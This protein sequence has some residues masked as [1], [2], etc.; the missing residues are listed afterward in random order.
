[1]GKQFTKS[2]FLK[3]YRDDLQQGTTRPSRFENDEDYTDYMIQLGFAI[4]IALQDEK[5]AKYAV[6]PEP[7]DPEKDIIV[8]EHEMYAVLQKAAARDQ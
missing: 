5:T 2:D 3:D 6:D 8:T 7:Y 1:M 4:I